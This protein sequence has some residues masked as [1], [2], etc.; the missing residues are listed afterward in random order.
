MLTETQTI[1]LGLI[2]N[3]DYFVKVLPHLDQEYFDDSGEKVVLKHIKEYH[4]KYDKPINLPALIIEI[5]NDNSYNELTQKK[6]EDILGKFEENKHVKYDAEWLADKAEEY[7]RNQAIRSAIITASSSY[8]NDPKAPPISAIPSLLEEAIAVTFDNSIGHDYIQDVEDRFKAYTMKE[9]KIP[10]GLESLNRATNGGV[11]KGT[12]N[13]FIS[14]PHGGKTGMMCK[15]A[16][17]H[18]KLGLNV[19]YVSLE[20]SPFKIAQRIDA[21]MLRYPI[22]DLEQGKV[23][24]DGM[25]AKIAQLKAKSIGKLKIKQFPSSSINSMHIKALLKELK[26]KEKFVPDVIYVD[27]MG[28]LLSSKASLKNQNSYTVQKM[29]SEELRALAVTENLAVFTAA[30][31]NRNADS[32]PEMEDVSES[33]GVVMTADLIFSVMKPKEKEIE[34][35]FVKVLKSRYSNKDSI[36]MFSLGFDPMYVDYFDALDNDRKQ[37]SQPPA[38]GGVGNKLKPTGFKFNK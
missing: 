9:D 30:Q 1:L 31:F 13:M 32:D 10:F 37:T 28:I 11:A 17:D 38:T 22:D 26:T 4:E 8:D 15:C 14:P 34:S 2:V 33:Y 16:G 36:S 5:G 12:L 21:S 3:D 7:C 20:M 27:Y 6:L 18:L 24:L 23:T 25:K 29:V 19:L 35:V